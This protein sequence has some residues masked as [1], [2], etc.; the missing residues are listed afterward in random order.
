MSD[1][2]R[3]SAILERGLDLPASDRDRFFSQEAGG[4]TALLQELRELSRSYERAEASAFISEPLAAAQPDLILNTLHPGQRIG[5]YEILEEAGRGGMGVVYRARDTRLG[6]DVAVKC[7]AEGASA[8]QRARLEHE[9][10]LAARLAHPSI[11]TIYALEEAPAAGSEPGQLYLISE[12]VAGETLRTRLARGPLPERDLMRFARAIADG[13]AAAHH[14][15][16]AHGDLKPENVVVRADGQ[17]KILDF[18]LAEMRREPA[19]VVPR[20]ALTGTPGYMAPE[21]LRGQ[22][23][24]PRAD[25]FA[26]GVLLFEMATGRHPFAGDRGAMLEA[27]L[28]SRAAYEAA[29][30]PA[31]VAAIVRRAL[32][33]DPAARY[34]S[35]A[36]LADALRTEA[37]D[38]PLRESRSVHWFIVHQRIVSALAAVMP[39]VMWIARPEFG[40]PWG[41][42]IFLFTMAGATIVVALRL[43]V[44]FIAREHPSDLRRHLL[45]VRR[46]LWMAELALATGVLIA[47]LALAD[48][49]DW[50]AGVLFGCGV[51]SI[52]SLSV[53]EPATTRAA[54]RALALKTDR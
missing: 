48:R 11:A 23:A 7:V 43:N 5:A 45:H 49:L 22:P 54:L 53:I 36:A 9:A 1:W 25:V 13:L 44:D 2:A 24:D 14:E 15:D 30:L 17:I 34:A 38:A 21:Q 4:D 16:I 42:L 50:A 12:F 3:V 41:S 29:D 39:L 28:S 10:R 47:G 40:R 37:P 32:S 46:R 19:P 6:R 27:A 20:E 35:G 51:A 31:S 33:P 18:G 26:F 8:S 52:I